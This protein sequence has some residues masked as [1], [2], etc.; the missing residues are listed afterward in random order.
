MNVFLAGGSGAMGKRL[1]PLLV[2]RGYRVAATTR[3]ERKRELIQRLGAEP[4][5]VDALD[6]AAVV[7]AV[8]R[9][10]PEVVIHQLTSLTGLSDL[11][12]FDREFAATNRLRTEGT[13]NLLEAAHAAAARRF[14]AQSYGNWNYARTGTEA[15]AED[16]PFDPRP[17][18][19]QVQSLEAIRHLE[20][21]VLSAGQI[22]GIVL[23]YGG[24]Y[25]PDTGLS[26]DGDMTELVRKRRF[27]IIGSG[28][29][30]WSLIQIDDAAA[31]TVA[32]IERGRPGVY[33]IVDDQPA[34]VA[35]WLPELA[36]AVGAKPP[37]HLPV[38]IGRLAVGEV[39]ISMMTQIRGA[40]NAKAR[41]ELG[42]APRYPSF[43]EGFRDG[44]GNGARP[45]AAAGTNSRRQA[46]EQ[47]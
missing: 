18:A 27:P 46:S 21:S 32:A 20:S 34:P 24:F 38:W 9:A 22:E 23:R 1:I 10:K 47:K 37:R 44:L 3:S 11:K 14:V 19:N 26:P 4:V 5:V 28:A 13:D 30:I 8:K 40:S 41:Q 12:H 43:R 39:G 16:A 6:R 35:E 31:A 45:A 17:P 25:G 29:G 7:E 42:W 2:D 36:R 15:K 33:N